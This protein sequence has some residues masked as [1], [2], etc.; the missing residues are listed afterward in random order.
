MISARSSVF[1]IFLSIFSVV[2][3]LG[4]IW[5]QIRYTVTYILLPQLFINSKHVLSSARP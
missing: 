2:D 1:N 4:G 5:L 3:I